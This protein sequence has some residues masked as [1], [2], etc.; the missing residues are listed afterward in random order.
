M[1]IAHIVFQFNSF[2]LVE[3]FQTKRKQ[4]GRRLRKPY[5][6]SMNNFHFTKSIY[7][8][9]SQRMKNQV[10]IHISHF[11]TIFSKKINFNFHFNIS[12]EINK[13]KFNDK[14]SQT[15]TRKYI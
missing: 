1:K 14:K 4:L 11:I 6:V 8:S 10:I 5:T 2:I 3:I 13:W 7:F 15:W 9:I 12:R